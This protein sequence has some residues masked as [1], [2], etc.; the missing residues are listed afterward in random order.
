MLEDIEILKEHRKLKSY[1][2]RDLN[3]LTKE[4]Y[5]KHI[6]PNNTMSDTCATCL[7]KMLDAL[8]GKFS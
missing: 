3:K 4:L 6:D 8:I 5:T 1:Y 7:T 2:K